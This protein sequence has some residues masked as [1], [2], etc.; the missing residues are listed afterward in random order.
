MPSALQ[1]GGIFL[2][3]SGYEYERRQGTDDRAQSGRT[4][5]A[6]LLLVDFL[7]DAPPLRAAFDA[8]LSALDRNDGRVALDTFHRA[9]QHGSPEGQLKGVSDSERWQR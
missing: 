5:R 7:G 8:V 4:Q 1:S 2:W 3:W 6:Q 9:T